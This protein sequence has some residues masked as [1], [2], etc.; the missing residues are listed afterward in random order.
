MSAASSPRWEDRIANEG[1]LSF[2]MFVDSFEK[3]NDIYY[4]LRV[5]TRF[6]CERQEKEV[7]EIISK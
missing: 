1:R 4:W 7:S 3:L 2:K 5:S 6:T